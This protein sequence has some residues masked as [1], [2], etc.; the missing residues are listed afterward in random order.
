MLELN[1]SRIS[2]L[3][4]SGQ[5]EAGIAA[6]QEALKREVG[7]VGERHFDTAAARG[8]L[9][10][11][12]SLAGRDADAIR[13]FKAAIPILMAASRENADDD[14]DTVSAARSQRLQNI[15][16]A[17]I[18]LL[19]R[20]SDNATGQVSLETFALADAIRGQSV[21]KALSASSARSVAKDP[22]LAELVRKEQ[23]LGKQVNA[24][25][26]ALNNALASNVR[27]E[28]V[29]KAT[30]AIDRQAARRPGE[31]ARG[32]QQALPE[33]RRTDRSEAADGRADQGGA[34]PGEAML[35]FYFGRR[36]SFVWAVPKDGPVAFAAINA[37]AGDIESKVR[38]LREALEPNAAMISDIPAF[39]LA[40][41]HELYSLLLKPVE[42]GWKRRR[43]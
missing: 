14:D 20:S 11:G 27:D 24:Q 33:L 31:G 3:Y 7:R 39:D 43:A 4:S 2:A 36:G 12:Y 6:A 25:L 22:A 13:E 23:D 16:E 10:V 42:A 15:V 40:L 29:V 35:S 17:Y 1:G 28:N 32:H 37:T 30:K 26:G 19:A 9:A 41:G 34:G 8:T 21:Q 18:A 38:K 5:I